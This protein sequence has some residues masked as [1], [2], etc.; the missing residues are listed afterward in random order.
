MKINFFVL[1][2]LPLSLGIPA[3]P[4]V[5][6]KPGCVT[7]G[8]PKFT[9]GTINVHIVAHS[10]DDVGWLKT[11]D[12]YYYG[13]NNSI[14][15]AGVQYIF[16][17]VIE[18]CSMNPDR[19]FTIV[20]QAFFQRWWNEQSA[21]V[22]ALTHKLV[23]NGQ[24]VFINGGWSMHDEACTHYISMIENTALGHRFILDQFGIAPRIGWQIDPFGHSAAQGALLSAEVGFDALYFARIDWQEGQTR[25]DARS[26]DLVWRGSPSFGPDGEVFT[27]VFPDQ[28]YGPPPGLCF[29]EAQCNGGMP[30]MD[31]ECLEDGNVQ[32]YIDLVV[33]VARRYANASQADLSAGAVNVLFLMGSD[34]QYENADEWYRNLDKLIHYV[35]KDGRVNAF[36]SNPEIYTDAKYLE[37][38]KR[39]VKT[40]DFMPL[41]N[42]AQSYWTGFFS[43]RPT[44]K[45]YERVQ[46]GYLQAARQLQMWANLPVN[47]YVS[48]QLASGQP[49]YRYWFGIGR[50]DMDPLAAAVALTQHHDAVTGTEKQHVAYDYAFRLAAGGAVADLAVQEALSVLTG[51]GPGPALGGE[52]VLCKLLNES[53]CPVADLASRTGKPFTIAVYNPL[54]ERRLFPVRVPVGSRSL[55]VVDGETGTPVPSVVAEATPT[56]SATQNLQ[57]ADES[58]PWVLTFPAPMRPFALRTFLVLPS[59]APST[60]SFTDSDKA[61]AATRGQAI[62]DEDEVVAENEH[63]RVT[64][65]RSS[66]LMTGFTNKDE[67][68]S[69]AVENQLLWYP[70]EQVRFAL[71]GGCC[72]TSAR[73]VTRRASA[74]ALFL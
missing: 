69:V 42:N 61:E 21:H 12:Q 38:V 13:A 41:A 45:R 50:H 30:V 8:A 25:T 40:D 31:D 1:A 15:H 5:S 68:V 57:S 59:S 62:A 65:S 48:S 11:V 37:G 9:A 56:A 26:M 74:L 27:G 18:Q 34:F 28:S 24:I 49:W 67:N 71:R 20:E 29:D 43:S 35:N 58:S 3:S 52:F 46:A 36:Y 39:P 4:R 47:K 17:T 54:S 19:K 53:S 64:F 14:Q 7:K 32:S 72:G 6:F 2:F 51:A 16:D 23:A 73:E 22:K 70:A 60:P 10:H 55:T 66:G 33:D 63:L 44:L